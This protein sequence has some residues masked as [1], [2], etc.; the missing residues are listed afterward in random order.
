MFFI[1]FLNDISF[2][3]SEKLS[4]KPENVWLSN[5]PNTN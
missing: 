4:P 2:E 1:N 5:L 3:S